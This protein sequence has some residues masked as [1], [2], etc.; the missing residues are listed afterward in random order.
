MNLTCTHN[1]DG[2]CASDSDSDIQGGYDN[3]AENDNG[4]NDF[5]LV[6]LYL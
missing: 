4:T 5:Y 6:D 3:N 2:N 1:R